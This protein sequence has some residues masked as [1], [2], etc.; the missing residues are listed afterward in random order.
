MLDLIVELGLV[1]GIIAT[2]IY[3]AEA[4]PISRAIGGFIL[5][6]VLIAILYL[7]I[8]CPYLAGAQIAIYS[9]AVTGLF[10]LA[11]SITK[12][13]TP[14][15]EAKARSW[16]IAG[17][18]IAGFVIFIAFFLTMHYYMYTPGIS[19][20]I[21]DTVVNRANIALMDLEKILSDYLWNYRGIDVL[22]QGVIVIAVAAGLA[23]FF[24][25]EK[26]GKVK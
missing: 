20:E 17:Y 23:N 1:I 25:R 6:S 3:V 15:D 8:N 9:G 10:L 5:F 18:L 2:A 14:E 22:M 4:R 21:V 7:Y 12:P 26:E 13:E 19:T 24:K 11:M 16:V